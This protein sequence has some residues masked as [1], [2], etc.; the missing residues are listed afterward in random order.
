MPRGRPPGVALDPDQ[1]GYPPIEIAGIDVDAMGHLTIP[2]RIA[3]GI[4][5]LQSNATQNVL[6]VL[7]RAGLMELHAWNPYGIDVV[8]KKTE[9]ETRLQTDLGAQ[10]I[11]TQLTLRYRRLVVRKDLE[12]NLTLDLRLHLG[13][14]KPGASR[15]YVMRI[16]DRIE[17]LARELLDSRLG[18]EHD[19]LADLR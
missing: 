19:D 3:A 13:V 6:G 9:L 17:L 16:A 5:W 2:T 14:Q 12:T 8:K 11:L 4:G 10:A 18:E 1:D 15:I 7:R